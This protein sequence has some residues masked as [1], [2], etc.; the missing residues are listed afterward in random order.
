MRSM[1]N[2][3]DQAP[4]RALLVD[5]HAIVREGLRALLDGSAEFEVVGE[6][7]DGREA[8]RRAIEL[9]PDVTV[10]DIAMPDLDGIEAVRALRR[11]NVASRIVMLTMHTAPLVVQRAFAAGAD[12]Y[13]VKTAAA[14]ELVAAIRAVR[15]G[16]RYLSR[17]LRSANPESPAA[18][19]D[20]PL[21][22]LSSRERQVLQ[23]V[24]EGYS[25]RRVADAVCLSPKSVDTYRSRLMRKL[26]VSNVAGLVKVAIRCGI[27][28][29]D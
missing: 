25:S 15:S 6:A 11:L 29:A 19:L 5:D 24:C 1:E 2:A 3:F 20:D 26:G 21:E 13:V 8:V 9:E 4:L 16:E 10:M 18:H 17:A 23:L 22:H 28:T 7:P 12:G 27:L 14:T